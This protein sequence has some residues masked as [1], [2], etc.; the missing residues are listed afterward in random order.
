M[1]RQR[2]GFERIRMLFTITRKYIC[3]SC[4]QSFRALDRRRT[5]RTSVGSRLKN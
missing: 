2:T 4:G 1:I 5:P 3:M